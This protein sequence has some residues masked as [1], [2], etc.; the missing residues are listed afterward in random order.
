MLKKKNF[1]QVHTDP[2]TPK[3]LDSLDNRM[4]WSTV[5]KA[6]VRSSRSKITELFLSTAVFNIFHSVHEGFK[7]RFV[8][9][10]LFDPVDNLSSD[11]KAMFILYRIAF[12]PARKPA[13]DKT[14]NTELSG[15][16]R[17]I[18]EREKI[19][20]IFMKKKIIIK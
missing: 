9:V 5:S 18:P 7:V 15:T 20:I 1:S 13:V 10:C 4:T 8:S 17:N 3:R 12:A 14:R 16:S 11:S 6:A 2:F 19:K